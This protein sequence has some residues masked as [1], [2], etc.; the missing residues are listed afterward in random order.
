MKRA[1]RDTRKGSLRD[2]R[3]GCLTRH[4][5]EQSYDRQDILEP[6]IESAFHK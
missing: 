6:M 4:L 3:R 5:N 2:R 1:L